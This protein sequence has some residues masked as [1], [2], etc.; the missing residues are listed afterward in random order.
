MHLFSYMT[1]RDL[2]LNVS[3]VC[4]RFKEIIRS[5]W[6]WKRRFHEIYGGEAFLD[7][8]VTSLQL[9]GVEGEYALSAC[10]KFNNSMDKS[11][12]SSE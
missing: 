8:S 10:S 9:C 4:R 1:A 7:D 2:V 6:F 11:T 5:E 3:V 12:V